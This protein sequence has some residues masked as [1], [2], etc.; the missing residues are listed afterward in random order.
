[1]FETIAVMIIVIYVLHLWDLTKAQK[2]ARK[3][4]RLK[5][6]IESCRF[7]NV[8][9]SEN[10]NYCIVCDKPLS[11]NEEERKDEGGNFVDW[12]DDCIKSARIELKKK[13]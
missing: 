6:N 12:C 10:L 9:Y 8:P 7:H 1:M 11:K 2:E 3:E 4:E 13:N 5:R